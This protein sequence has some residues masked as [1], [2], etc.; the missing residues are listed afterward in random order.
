MSAATATAKPRV[1]AIRRNRLYEEVARQIEEMITQQMKPGDMLPPERQLAERFGVSRSSIR[2]AI[3]RLE[4][5]GLVEPRQGAGTVVREPG[6]ETLMNP[7]AA[8]L[9]Q[10]RSLVAELF[11]VRL[12]LEPPLAARAA[13][14]A[15]DREI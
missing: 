15:S 9:R 4:H 11:E 5:V 13:T 1:D 10:K 14:H 7:L 2:D 8:I 3:R 6:G 12:M